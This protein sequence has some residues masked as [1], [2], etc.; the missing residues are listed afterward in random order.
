M[1]RVRMYLTRVVTARIKTAES[2]ARWTLRATSL[3]M[4]SEEPAVSRVDARR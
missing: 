4:L 3:V 1:L 2:A